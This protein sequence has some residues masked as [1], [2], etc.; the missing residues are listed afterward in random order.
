[1]GADEK[2]VG[3]Q[4]NQEF[5]AEP[6]G[7]FEENTLAD[8][9]EIAAVPSESPEVVAEV[10]KSEAEPK[11]DKQFVDIDAI[12]FQ[13]ERQEVDRDSSSAP[14]GAE[15]T[16]QEDPFALPSNTP[17]MA[18]STRLKVKKKGFFLFRW[19]FGRK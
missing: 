12:Q 10:E 13:P 11:S 14:A 15:Q 2:I 17:K 16:G 8:S 1:L 7:S 4:T 3:I 5:N 6:D 18:A 9:Q 19:L